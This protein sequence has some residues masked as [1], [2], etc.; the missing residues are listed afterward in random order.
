ML[1]LEMPEM[2]GVEALQHMHQRDP[3]VRVIVFTAF[4]TDDRILARARPDPV[5]KVAIVAGGGDEV[6]L[7]EEAEA[8]GAQVYIT[9]E[10]YTRS[11][12]QDEGGRAW[13]AANRAAC[14]AYAE[15]SRMALLGFSHAATEFLVL[16]REMA[17]F[18]GERGLRVQA[19]A[20]A[21]W[22]R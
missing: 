9:G 6:E 1:D 18:F 12:P 5:E 14:E 19:L 8:D 7:M 10:W 22:W 21:D 11:T 3:N 20:Q 15:R 13:T 16:R 4:D 17:G 2:D